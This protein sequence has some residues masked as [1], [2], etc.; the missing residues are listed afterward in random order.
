[1]RTAA[2]CLGEHATKREKEAKQ[3]QLVRNDFEIEK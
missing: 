3:Q 1:V 2:A